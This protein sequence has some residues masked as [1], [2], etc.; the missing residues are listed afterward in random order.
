[1]LTKSMSHGRSSIYQHIDIE[2]YGQMNVLL[3]TY[4]LNKQVNRRGRKSMM[5]PLL[6]A[7]PLTTT[8]AKGS[9]AK[10]TTVCPISSSALSTLRLSG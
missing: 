5:H 9:L 2:F 10:A 6:A 1:M 4:E 8:E 3:K 7:A